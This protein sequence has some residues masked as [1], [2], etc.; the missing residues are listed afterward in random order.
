M[1]VNFLSCL[2]LFSSFW[3]RNVTF[4]SL[5]RLPLAA[6]ERH[7]PT[8]RFSDKPSGRILN[9]TA[10]THS[11]MW[12]LFPVF[13]KLFYFLDATFTF[14]S[15]TLSKTERRGWKVKEGLKPRHTSHRRS[16]LARSRGT[17]GVS[18]PER[19]L[20]LQYDIKAA[21]VQRKLSL[22]ASISDLLHSVSTCS[23]I[24]N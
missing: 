15:T 12:N 21:N 11:Q 1:A 10:T 6:E 7:L 14:P 5:R 8:V 24:M 3:G 16:S 23:H 4:G 17:L 18:R 22:I 20:L 2:K 13:F 19:H 9:C